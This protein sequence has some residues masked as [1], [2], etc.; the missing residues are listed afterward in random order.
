M[1]NAKITLCCCFEMKLCTKNPRRQLRAR[2]WLRKP[3]LHLE[4]NDVPLITPGMMPTIKDSTNISSRWFDLFISNEKSLRTKK[5]LVAWDDNEQLTQR[6]DGITKSWQ[7]SRNVKYLKEVP[8][9]WR[10]INCPP[11]CIKCQC[12][13]ME[14]FEARAQ[15]QFFVGVKNIWWQK[16]LVVAMFISCWSSPLSGSLL[17]FLPGPKLTPAHPSLSS[18]LVPATTNYNT[19]RMIRANNISFTWSDPRDIIVM[20]IICRWTRQ[21]VTSAK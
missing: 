8:H 3:V 20:R 14:I 17:S 21:A 19:A 4:A 2:S 10:N 15:K 11:A 1:G 7:N 5:Y 12:D 13:A 18:C 16:L 6:Q 9:P